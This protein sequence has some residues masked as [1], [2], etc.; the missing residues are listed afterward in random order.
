MTGVGLRVFAL[1]LALGL[2][3]APAAAAAE[4]PANDDYLFSK[5]LEDPRTGSLPHNF[6]FN[7]IVDTTA[8]TVQADLFSP[9]RSGGGA[10]PTVCNGVPFGKTVWYDLLPDVPGE[11]EVSAANYDTVIAIYRFDPRT[12]RIV[13]SGGC[14][15]DAISESGRFEVRAGRSYTVQIGG[16][17]NGQGPASGL[18][19]VSISFFADQDGDGI[20]DGIDK[21]P[22]LPGV[23]AAGGCPPE[24]QFTFNITTTASALPGIVLSAFK[25][26]VRKA[27]RAR[28]ELRCIHGCQIRQVWRTR[29]RRAVEF[30]RFDGRRLPAGAS[31]ELRVTAP[32]FIGTYTRW[33]VN[34]RGLGNR[35]DR[36]TLPGSRKP[37]RRCI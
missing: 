25:L 5:A 24:L 18:L 32:G 29:G 1:G 37:R 21:C 6:R 28:A 30:T 13:E 26:S 3:C 15:N 31:L 16:V 7:E 20:I 2:A 9:P 23:E 34:D 33:R 35:V 8:A 19:G 22:E 4:P 27:P 11:V 10:E 17:D 12:G 14:L 36:C